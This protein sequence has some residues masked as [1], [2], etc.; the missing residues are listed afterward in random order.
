MVAVHNLSAGRSRPSSTSGEATGVDDLLELREHRVR[1]G[2]LGF[3]LG[4]FGYL[5]LRARR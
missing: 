5:W 1:A 4:P 2:R 3:Q